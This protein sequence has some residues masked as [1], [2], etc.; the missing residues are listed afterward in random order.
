MQS[1]KCEY[2]AESKSKTGQDQ[3]RRVG[4]HTSDFTLR[5]L[6][7]ALRTSC[8]EFQPFNHGPLLPFL[9]LSC[10]FLL[11]SHHSLGVNV[12]KFIIKWGKPLEGVVRI[13]GAKNASLALM[14][15][16]I[17]SPGSYTLSNTPQLRDVTTMGSLLVSMGFSISH[18]NHTMKVDSAHMT[19]FE[20]PYE[21]VKKMRASI[22]VLGPMLSR[23]GRAKVSLPGGCGGVPRRNPGQQVR[24][25]C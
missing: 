22:Y 6:C 18:E 4:S 17:L 11:S 13:S 15:A 9:P 8:F 1:A 19:K 16:T 24:T 23:Y 10:I 14:P 20:A 21:H 7:V 25:G 2:E 5:S 3:D 12:D